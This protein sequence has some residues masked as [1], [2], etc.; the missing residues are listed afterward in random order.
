MDR[1]P[2]FKLIPQK[3]GIEKNEMYH[4]FNNGIACNHATA[5]SAKKLPAVPEASK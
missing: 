2:I 4:F 1:P 5:D 3:G